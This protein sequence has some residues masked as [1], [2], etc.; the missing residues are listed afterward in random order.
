MSVC[1]AS[2]AQERALL[3]QRGVNLQ[4]SP[5]ICVGGIC[6]GGRGSGIPSL[7]QPVNTYTTV[8]MAALA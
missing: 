5:L 7:S 6:R 8:E 3:L 1:T 2:K 4:N